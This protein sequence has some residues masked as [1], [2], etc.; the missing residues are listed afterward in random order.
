MPIIYTERLREYPTRQEIACMP[1]TMLRS[2][3][4]YFVPGIHKTILEAEFNQLHCA[5]VEIFDYTKMLRKI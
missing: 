5:T 4:S 3:S 1:T 2:L